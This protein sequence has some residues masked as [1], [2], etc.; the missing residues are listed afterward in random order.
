MQLLTKRLAKQLPMLYGTE[1]TELGDKVALAK[2]FHP[3][4]KWTWYVIEYDGRDVCWGL[5]DGEEVEFGYFSIN[6]IS[7]P[8]GMFQLRAERDLFFRPTKVR[9]LPVYGIDRVSA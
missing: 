9:D 6:E 4:S 2:F 3:A 1:D 8:A 7:Q 5:V